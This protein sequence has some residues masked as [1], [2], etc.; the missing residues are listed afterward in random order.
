MWMMRR[1]VL[2]LKVEDFGTKYF[3]N[4]NTKC[5]R[6]IHDLLLFP[7]IGK[8]HNRICYTM[9]QK[10]NR[11]FYLKS[12]NYFYLIIWCFLLNPPYMAL[13]IY[14][15][16]KIWRLAVW[17]IIL[18][19]TLICTVSRIGTRTFGLFR[20]AWD[21]RAFEAR[22]DCFCRCRL[23]NSSPHRQHIGGITNARGAFLVVAA[24]G[25]TSRRG[26][27]A[28][29]ERYEWLLTGKLRNGSLI[30]NGRFCCFWEAVLH[31]RS[32][33]HRP[34][35]IT[36]NYRSISR[37]WKFSIGRRLNPTKPPVGICESGPKEAWA[38]FK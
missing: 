22:P 27:V 12:E 1:K 23:A 35:F 6:T 29:R 28:L 8:T 19:N 5:V 16:I 14:V 11:R 18:Y 9:R 13:K 21:V 37:P 4:I 33:L 26:E 31:T 20:V 32:R 25:W 34:P 2:H 17:Y 36:P 15:C 30:S 10:I 3:I 24:S 7:I 38:T